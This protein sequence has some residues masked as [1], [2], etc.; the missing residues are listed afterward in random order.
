MKSS[1]THQ[2]THTNMKSSNT[3]QH[4]QTWKAVGLA[5]LCM[6]TRKAVTFTTEVTGSQGRRK[7]LRLTLPLHYRFE[8]TQHTS[9]LFQ[10]Q[11]LWIPKKEN[12]K[13]SDQNGVSLLYIVLEIHHSGREPSKCRLCAAMFWAQTHPQSFTRDLTELVHALLINKLHPCE[14]EQAKGCFFREGRGGGGG[15]GG[16]FFPKCRDKKY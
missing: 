13:L 3:S 10:E 6:H 16:C 4:I 14:E 7:T 1:N 2:S 12:L 15:G 11:T 9:T 8:T 5:S